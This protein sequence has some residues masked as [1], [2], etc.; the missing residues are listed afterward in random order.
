MVGLGGF[1]LALPV[2]KKLKPWVTAEIPLSPVEKVSA[3]SVYADQLNTEKI[4]CGNLIL[5]SFFMKTHQV[6][7]VEL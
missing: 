1:Y 7:T 3:Y 5:H 6:L 4:F 2:T